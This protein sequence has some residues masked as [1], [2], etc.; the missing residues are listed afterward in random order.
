M[1]INFLISVED[2]KQLGLIHD[3]VDTKVIKYTIQ[4]VQDMNI[5]TAT[6]SPLYRELLRRVADNDWDADYRK[7]MEEYIAKSIVAHAN[8]HIIGHL[9]NKITNKA[10]G[11]VSDENLSANTAQENNSYKSQLRKVAQFYDERLIG[12]LKDN[13]E[14]YPE[15]KVTECNH[16][17]VKKSRGGFKPWLKV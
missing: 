7:L 15:Y 5:Q 12:Y 8:V 13:C 14:L 11:A 17:D 16:E 2:L 10:T 1:T 6:G 3:N 4:T 9:N